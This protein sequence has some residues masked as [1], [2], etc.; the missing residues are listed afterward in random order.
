MWETCLCCRSIDLMSAWCLYFVLF[1][2]V[3]RNLKAERADSFSSLK[4][5]ISTNRSTVKGCFLKSQQWD[6]PSSEVIIQDEF[7][8]RLNPVEKSPACWRSW[9]RW[10]ISIYAWQLSWG[11]HRGNKMGTLP[12]NRRVRC[13][14]FIF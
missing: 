14:C 7:K 5:R 6:E 8:K 10:G 12:S 2:F 13:I 1:C 9:T 11:V 4:G 3:L